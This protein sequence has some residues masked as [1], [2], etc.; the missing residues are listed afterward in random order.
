MDEY[1]VLEVD[2]DNSNPYIDFPENLKI[3]D[4]VTNNPNY[5]NYV[6]SQKPTKQIQKL[7][8]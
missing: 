5:D 1:A 4:D 3:I 8:S 7:L 6:I 2:L